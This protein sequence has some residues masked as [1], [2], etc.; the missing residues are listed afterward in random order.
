MAARVHGHCGVFLVGHVFVFRSAAAS[1]ASVGVFGA[2]RVP[3]TGGVPRAPRGPRA[4]KCG[5]TS[6][7]FLLGYRSSQASASVFIPH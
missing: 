2:S 6:A 5:R 3:R 4:P 1:P 7:P